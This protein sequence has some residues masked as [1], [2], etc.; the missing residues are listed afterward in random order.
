MHNIL[1]IPS[2]VNNYTLGFTDQIE[3][4]EN[5]I[6]QENTITIIDS[7]V[8]KLYP[9]LQRNSNTVIECTEEAKTLNG[10]S[11]I[12]SKLSFLKA[13]IRT[14]LVV[15]GGGV[16]QDVVGFCA[17]IYSR[18]VEYILVNYINKYS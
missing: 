13:N 1:N 16:L 14:K 6:D 4:I 12:L 7:N 18:G 5:L 2:K 3:E 11:I 10:A 17:S 15:I 9:N 8:N